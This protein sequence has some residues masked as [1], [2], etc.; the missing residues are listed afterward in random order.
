MR[1]EAN[2]TGLRSSNTPTLPNSM[3]V[4]SPPDRPFPRLIPM[5]AIP[6]FGFLL[7]L[8]GC[9]ALLQPQAVPEP[10]DRTESIESSEAEAP[11]AGEGDVPE[12][13]APRPTSR[14]VLLDSQDADTRI[15]ER[16]SELTHRDELTLPDTETGYY[17]DVKEAQLRQ[18]F[19]S[20][21]VGL[22]RNENSILLL[23]SGMVAFDTDSTRLN[24]EA[25]SILDTLASVLVEYR[26]TL[27]IVNSHTDRSGDR[28]VNQKLSE[29]RAI[30]VANYLHEQGL[31]SERIIAVGH[32]EENP[33]PPQGTTPQG[34]RWP[35]R[36]IEISLEVITEHAP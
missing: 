2:T 23:I 33:L 8:N 35:D 21:D 1:H 4:L 22:F 12:E 20:R 19:P 24:P 16:T 11:A 9:A 28:D 13:D 7:I 36:R 30:A 31:S 27:V 34:D 26:K 10:I 14:I 15:R 6:A 5:R 3:P 25:Q 32:G 29:A 18:H 17:L